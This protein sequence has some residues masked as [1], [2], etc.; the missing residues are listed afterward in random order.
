LP[1]AG[2]LGLGV[3]GQAKRG[4]TQTAYHFTALKYIFNTTVLK[5]PGQK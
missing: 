5:L 4:G 2:G 3:K 1:A